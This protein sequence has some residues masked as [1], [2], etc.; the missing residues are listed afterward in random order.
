MRQGGTL[1][2]MVSY[3]EIDRKRGRWWEVERERETE[4]GDENQRGREGET[5][6]RRESFGLRTSQAFKLQRCDT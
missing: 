2:E 5:E 6:R 3:I 1:R 4:R